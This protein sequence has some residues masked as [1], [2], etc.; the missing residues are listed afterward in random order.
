MRLKVAKCVVR[1]RVLKI[2]VVVLV[3]NGC[4]IL[5]LQKIPVGGIL[6]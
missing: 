2:E 1:I 5:P 4:E 6:N 3:F